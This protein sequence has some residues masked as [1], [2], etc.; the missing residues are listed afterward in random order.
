[1]PS[2]HLGFF[3]WSAEA[4]L[5]LSRSKPNGP[6][7]PRATKPAR[8]PQGRFC[9]W[10]LRLT[11]Q[12]YSHYLPISTGRAYP[13]ISKYPTPRTLAPLRVPSI[14]IAPSQ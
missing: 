7:V 12:A 2:L 11:N 8:V 13:V 3:I 9:T 6:N 14:A 5:P 10:V 1:V 4:Q